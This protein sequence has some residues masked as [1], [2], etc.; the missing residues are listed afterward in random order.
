VNISARM[1]GAGAVLFVVLFMVG[2]FVNFPRESA[3]ESLARRLTR[4][5]ML[6][7][8]TPIH[9]VWFGLGVDEVRIS[10]MTQSGPELVLSLQEVKIPLTWKLWRGLTA[11]GKVGKEGQ[12]EG[13]VEWWGG[14]VEV[15]F[16]QVS[17]EDIPWIARQKPKILRGKLTGMGRIVPGGQ[18]APPKQ[19]NWNLTMETLYL[20]G[21]EVVGQPVPVTR[22]DRV[23]FTGIMEQS[24]QIQNL[25]LQGD[26]AGSITGTIQPMWQSPVMSTVNLDVN[27]AMQYD[28]M[29]Q[30]GLARMFLQGY[31]TGNQLS[32]AVKGPLMTA[33]IQRKEPGK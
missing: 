16:D 9:P 26:I 10:E 19:A 11:E 7:E 14:G 27:L 28:W 20:E 29:N 18:G 24:I 5:G 17:L 30:L 6:V 21:W 3:T 33:E 32:I 1:K 4:D 8:L 2:F 23:E 13:V 22:I 15:Q 25:A 12:L 31:M